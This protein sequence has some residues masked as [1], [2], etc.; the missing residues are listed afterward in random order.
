ML[1]SDGG[2][3]VSAARRPVHGPNHVGRVILSI[4]T[5][6]AP[7]KLLHNVNGSTGLA[8]SHDGGLYALTSLTTGAGVRCV[9]IVVKPDRLPARRD[10]GAAV[11]QKAEHAAA[12]AEPTV[13]AG[14]VGVL[15][16]AA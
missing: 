5:T 1:T 2:G 7:K 12:P 4:T 6:T 3:A 16:S 10:L 13:G 14:P 8:L 9:D 15:S 11:L